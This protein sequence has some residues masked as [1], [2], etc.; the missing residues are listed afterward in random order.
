MGR[1]P[2]DSYFNGNPWYLITLA[3]AEQLYDALY[4]WKQQGSITVTT[5]SLAFFKDFASSVSTGT[6]SSSSSTYATLYKAIQTY[7]DGYVNIVA[8]YTP[9][10][11]A[12]AEQ[13][14]KSTEHLSQPGTSPGLM[15]LSSLPPH[16]EP[17]SSP[18]PGLPRTGTPFREPVPP[19]LYLALTVLQQPPISPPARRR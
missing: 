8:K 18:P 11:G 6:F 17:A 3:A 4:V 15:L 5:T 2:E 19:P 10:D 12:L 16:V 13:F 7:A 14:D 9:S 1:Y